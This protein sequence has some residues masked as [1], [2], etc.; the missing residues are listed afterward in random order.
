M[1]LN[2]GEDI[3]NRENAAQEKQDSR[4][5]YKSR[6]LEN[7]CAADLDH[8]ATLIAANV[9]RK[10]GAAGG[11]RLKTQCFAAHG[12]QI[13]N[14]RRERCDVSGSGPATAADQSH[15]FRCDLPR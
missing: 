13:R 3:D 8:R 7:D 15:A 11:F 10:F 5:D 1:L 9:S 6:E 2:I 4:D 14:C 12:P